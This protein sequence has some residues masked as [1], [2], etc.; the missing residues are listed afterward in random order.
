[1]ARPALVNTLIEQGRSRYKSW[2]DRR[3]PPSQQVTLTQ[4][5]IFIFPNR[6]A[7]FYFI[8]VATLWIAATNYENNL[9]FGLGFL[10][11]ALF[12]V[13]ILHTFNNMSG[14]QLSVVHVPTVFAGEYADV[15][16][17][18]QTR[19]GQNRDSLHIG[20]HKEHYIHTGLVNT[21]QQRIKVPVQATRRG[22]FNPG[23]IT[24]QTTFPLG[25]IRSWT[26]MDMDVRILTY[27]KPVRF[28]DLQA[29]KSADGE[30]EESG[31]QKGSEEFDS[32]QDYIP[33]MSL[34]QVS[35]KHA[36]KGQ[37]LKARE[38]ID[39]TES[40]L[41]LDW[42]TLPTLGVEER[43]STLCYWALESEKSGEVYGLRMPGVE[44]L[45]DSGAK[46]MEQVLTALALYGQSGGEVS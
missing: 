13:A 10:L 42:E 38:F 14:L 41:W 45:P 4:K 3:I 34:R 24:I 19:E 15:E 26:H 6:H 23:R 30:G 22:W 21:P 37:G 9:A 18:L 17:L 33:G 31:T 29:V 5:N 20:W 16:F 11:I 28:A 44:V 12:V 32:L 35:W 43:L 46:H 7:L 25:I 2:I 1:M 36:A 8:V 39:Y 27:P 40:F